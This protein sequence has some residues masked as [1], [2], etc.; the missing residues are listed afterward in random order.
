MLFVRDL[1]LR[2]YLLTGGVDGLSPLVA[3]LVRHGDA[4]D[5]LFFVV[6][7][8]YIFGFGLWRRETQRMLETIGD[9]STPSPCT[10]RS[11]RGTWPSAWP[12]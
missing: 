2:D 10:G 1:A 8:A 3:G 11:R 7:L 5:L 9:T 12:S 6:L 4:F